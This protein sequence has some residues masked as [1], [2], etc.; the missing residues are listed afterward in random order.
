VNLTSILTGEAIGGG[1]V[2][3]GVLLH[4]R[5]APRLRKRIATAKAA[6]SKPP[7]ARE[8]VPE[9]ACGVEYGLLWAH[10]THYPGVPLRVHAH[11]VEFVIRV[12]ET[13]HL[14]FKAGEPFTENGEEW[15][16]V[17]IG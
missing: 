1:L 4:S 3:A 8:T 13:K 5:F 6:A 16:E 9:F 7:T 2:A 14:A 10:V 11:M 17:T 15:M 12:A